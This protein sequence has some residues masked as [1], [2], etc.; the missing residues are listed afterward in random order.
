MKQT[1]KFLKM[2]GLGN[3]FIL[4]DH[5]VTQFSK[6]LSECAS[7]LC[8]RK[9]SIGADGLV[10]ITKSECADYKIRIFNSDGSEAS[11]CGNALRCLGLYL[12]DKKGVRSHSI[13]IETLAGLRQIELV[14]H[15]G[16]IKTIM[17]DMGVPKIPAIN[18]LVNELSISYKF[19]EHITLVDVGNPHAVVFTNSSDLNVCRA[20]ALEISQQS[21][22]KDGINVEISRLV[23]TNRIEAIV[24]ERGAGFTLACG[25]GAVA[26]A[27]VAV[28]KNLATYPLLISMPGG[29]IKVFK[30]ETNSFIE[31]DCDFNFYGEVAI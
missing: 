27:H 2:N 17:V 23:D 9:Y 10:V 24:L 20:L 16:L 4:I 11:M 31:A 13:S 18:C 8:N 7:T 1:L 29:F 28:L 14:S 3:D 19:I 12:Y 15:D 30:K 25:S 6:D 5:T 21:L 22:F 26:I